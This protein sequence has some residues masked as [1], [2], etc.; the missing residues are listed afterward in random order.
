MCCVFHVCVCVSVSCVCVGLMC[1]CWSHVCVSVSCV[2]VCVSCVCV[3]VSR[4]C[5]CVCVCVRS[6]PGPPTHIFLFLICFFSLSIVPSLSSLHRSIS[7]PYFT[8]MWSSP[9]LSSTS[10][11]LCH[12]SLCPLAAVAL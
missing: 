1:V 8:F 10:R 5:V 6:Y 9:L 4:V 7:L 2:C 12:P 3:S 11:S